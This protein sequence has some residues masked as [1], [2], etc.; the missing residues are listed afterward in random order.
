VARD[1]AEREYQRALSTHDTA[2]AA[3]ARL[4]RSDAPLATC[5]QL[6]VIGEPLEPLEAFRAARRNSSAARAAA[7]RRRAGQ[8]GCDANT[9]A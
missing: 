7:R 1:R 4:L 3:L 8:A 5:T 9:S 2:S 6:F